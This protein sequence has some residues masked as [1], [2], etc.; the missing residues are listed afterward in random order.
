[1]G[2]LCLWS[3]ACSRFRAVTFVREFKEIDKF[4][5]GRAPTAHVR[6]ASQLGSYSVSRVVKGLKDGRLRL[7]RFVGMGEVADQR[8]DHDAGDDEQELEDAV[9]VLGGHGHVVI[10]G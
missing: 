4:L 8:H 6:V 10:A 5:Q 7:V 9:V 2:S 1:M 3:R